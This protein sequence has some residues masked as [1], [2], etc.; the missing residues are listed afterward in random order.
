MSNRTYDYIVVGA[1]AAGCVVAARL[2]GDPDRRVLLLEAGG[3][4]DRETIH[5]TDIPSMTSMWG[6][7]DVNWPYTTV[8]QRG[9]GGRVVPIPQGRVLGGSSS[10]NAMMYVRGNRR[11]FDHWRDLGNDGWGYRDVLPYFRR[12]ERFAGE[13][14]AYRGSH[15]PLSVVEYERPSSVAEAFVRATRELGLARTVGDYNGER[16]E[17][18]AFFYQSTRT[19]D[20]R[21]CSTATA[22]LDPVRGHPGLTLDTR[23]VTTRIL[24]DGGRAVGVE[25]H[26]DGEVHQAYAD[27]EVIVAC[28]ALASPKL[29]MLS[30]VGPADT[31]SALGIA[32]LVDLPGVG[33]NLHDHVLFGVGYESLCS[34][35]PPRL[36]AEAGLFTWSRRSGAAGSPAD[37]DGPDL[38]FFFG[39][40]Q[41]VDDRYKTPGPGFTFAPI[42]TRPQSRGTVTLR[43][44]DPLDLPVVDPNYLGCDADLDVLLAGLGL[45]RELAASDSFRAYRGRELAPGDGVAGAALADYVRATASTVWHPV[46]TCRMGR[47]GES[48]VDRELRVHGTAGLRVVD[49][50]VMPRITTGN[51]NAA[52]IMIAERAVDLIQ[53]AAA[54]DTAADDTMVGGPAL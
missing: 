1:G 19:P 32:P 46:G 16:Q 18:I 48:V 9:L 49:A 37:A 5:R 36:L 4:D 44:A 17:N 8:P 25:Y 11:D 6:P 34:L 21:R 47:D 33:R 43:S 14:S 38:Q 41:Y 39:P 42:L 26:R 28:G 3:S 10:I 22:Y 24:F 20:D 15:G 40:V 54:P 50:S 23:A 31:V 2:L 29:L 30:G 45:A 35:P 13:A 12:A 7:S 52:T 51:P 27:A 53:G